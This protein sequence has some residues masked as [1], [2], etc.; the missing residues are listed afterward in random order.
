MFFFSIS[1]RAVGNG[2]SWSGREKRKKRIA[3]NDPDETM[4]AKDTHNFFS[5]ILS[6]N[7]GI[8]ENKSEIANLRSKCLFALRLC[9][10]SLVTH[11]RA[12]TILSRIVR[13]TGKIPLKTSALS[14]KINYYNPSIWYTYTFLII[15]WCNYLQN[16]YNVKNVDNFDFNKKYCNWR[17]V[18]K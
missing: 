6:V 2:L 4:R 3:R 18:W 16:S 5:V 11:F 12:R 14:R 13:F 8:R 7:A 1:E 10:T 15:F 17:K 9:F